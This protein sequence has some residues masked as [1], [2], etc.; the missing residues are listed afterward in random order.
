ML[1]YKL[2]KKTINIVDFT[3][4]IINTMIKYYGLLKSI[5]SNKSSLFISKFWFYYIISLKLSKNSLPY[6]TVK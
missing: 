5:I 4:N 2:V 6:S 3:K 1:Y